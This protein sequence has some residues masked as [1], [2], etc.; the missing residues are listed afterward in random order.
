MVW[1]AD[2]RFAG[3]VDCCSAVDTVLRVKPGF[4]PA[5][6]PSPEGEFDAALDMQGLMKSALV[7][8]RSKAQRKL[9]YHWQR[10]G[11]WLFS[12]AVRPDPTSVHIVD[13]YVDVARAAGGVA[14]RAEFAL[15]PS[16]DA[17]ASVSAMVEG[18]Y[19]VF[20]P[21]AGWVTKRWPPGH[22]AALADRAHAAGVRVVLIGG[23]ADADRAAADE[24]L[25]ACA[26]PPLDLVGN[27]SVPELVALLAGARFHVGGD[28]G[29]SHIAAALGVPAIGLYS[30][31]R[32][33]RSCPY[34]QV[35][36][37]HYDADALGNIA[38]DAV[39]D[40]LLGVMEETA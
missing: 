10:E 1:A 18:P 16:P 35:E 3:I 26:D 38:P 33:A 13:Q 11:A 5:S 37:C 40:T 32:P 7:V 34:G 6:W 28:T 19:A 21:G 17:V 31:T 24:V 9:G 27:T 8:A 30:I 14:D 23:R 15:S 20:N 2:P 12:Q 4:R 22:F 36:R 25:G 29:S 39:W